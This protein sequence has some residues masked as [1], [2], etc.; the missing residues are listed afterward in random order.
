MADEELDTEIKDDTVI[1]SDTE[2]EQPDLDEP[3]EPDTPVDPEPEPEP[4]PSEKIVKSFIRYYV[5]VDDMVEEEL[6]VKLY[7]KDTEETLYNPFVKFEVEEWEE[8]EDIP[9]T[10][11]LIKT[12]EEKVVDEEEVEHLITTRF[13]FEPYNKEVDPEPIVIRNFCIDCR[14]CTPLSKRVHG[15]CSKK[16]ENIGSGFKCSNEENVVIDFV[17]GE[18]MLK[19]CRDFNSNGLCKLF[20]EIPE[21]E[22]IEDEI[23]EEPIED[24]PTIE[25]PTDDEP[26]VDEP[27]VPSEEEPEVPS[28]EDL[29]EEVNG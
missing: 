19:D 16:I 26:V 11:I 12:S 29:G 27:E 17:T 10:V 18:Q 22:I 20:E 5:T 8:I 1:P 24:E 15:C 21:E 28:E 6:T 7:K 14:W 4:E 23:P 2:V 3:T 9:D 25:E 13:Y